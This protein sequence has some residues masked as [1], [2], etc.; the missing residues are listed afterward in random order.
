MLFLWWRFSHK[1]PQLSLLPFPSDLILVSFFFFLINEQADCIFKVYRKIFTFS[2]FSFSLGT[3][4]GNIAQKLWAI[5]GLLSS[6]YGSL[7]KLG[8]S[9][10][11]FTTSHQVC[12]HLLHS[13]QLAPLLLILCPTLM[14]WS[15]TA[16]GHYLQLWS[17]S[18]SAIHN[19][20]GK[21]VEVA[22]IIS[23]C[24]GHHQIKRR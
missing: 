9:I 21:G 1:L 10:L 15:G 11:I 18:P 19:L 13:S 24:L 23:R 6:R 12:T 5:K 22:S 17:P 7:L 3:M 16:S 4:L 14:S 20:S 2:W 8:Y